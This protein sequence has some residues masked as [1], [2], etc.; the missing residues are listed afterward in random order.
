L[1]KQPPYRRG[2]RACDRCG[3][4]RDR[5]VA[6]AALARLLRAITC[7]ALMVCA[8]VT[9]DIGSC[10]SHSHFHSTG[11]AG[12]RTDGTHRRVWGHFTTPVSSLKKYCTYSG[13]YA[14]KVGQGKKFDCMSVG[15]IAGTMGAKSSYLWVACVHGP[16]TVREHMETKRTY[17]C[18]A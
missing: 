1:G 9:D 13:H 15:H 5:V 3:S 6:N 17:W 11:E 7:N 12:A 4:T 8:C 16:C 10:D 2:R 14:A 18:A